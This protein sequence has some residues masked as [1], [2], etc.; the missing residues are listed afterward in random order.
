MNLTH[1][2]IHLIAEELSALL[3]PARLQK[4]FDADTGELI[5]QFRS[6]GLT[7]HLLLSLQPGFTRLH[8][9]DQKPPRQPRPTAWTML[10][11]KWLQGAWLETIQTDPRDRILTMTFQAIPPNWEPEDEDQRAPRIPLYLQLE[12]FAQLPNAFLLQGRQLLGAARSRTLFDRPTLAG[13]IYEPPPPPPDHAAPDTSQHLPLD[14]LPAD[15]SRSELLE[16]T[17]TELLEEH[18]RTRLKRNLTSALKSQSRRLKR[19]IQN[20]EDDLSRIEDADEY[21]RRGELLQSAYGKVP[22]GASSAE[23]PD[24]YTPGMP[25]VE[26]PLDPARSLAKNIERYFHHY[27]RYSQARTEV[28]ERLLE[29]MEK[30][31]LLQSFRRELA[32]IDD[33]DQL[34]ALETRLRADRILPRKQTSA[35]PTQKKQ[36]ALPPYRKFTGRSGASI[37]VGRGA[38]HNDELTTSVAR[39]RDIWLHARD[40]AG[41]HVLIRMNKNQEPHHEDLLDAATLAAHFSRGRRDTLI[42]ITY[43]EAKFVRKPPGAAPGLVTVA[44]GSTLAIR[45]DPERLQRLLDSE[46]EK[47]RR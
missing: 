34:Q 17:Y 35:S 20:I 21:R 12:L 44:G 29:I 27:R 2:E 42:D 31:E 45:P 39:G 1:K 13:R 40:W 23:V 16:T 25:L 43:T 47:T 18:R 7:S 15:G 10:L 37:L 8:L 6:P 41:A 14:K 22:N 46:D 38:R 9:I 28:E 32:T 4:V 19:L 3:L 26:I 5:L 24:F 11:R 33:L 36:Q 30:Q